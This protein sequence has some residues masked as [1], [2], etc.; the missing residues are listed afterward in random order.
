MLSMKFNAEKFCWKLELRWCFFDLDDDDQ[1]IEN[2]TEEESNDEINSY[3]AAL[4]QLIQTALASGKKKVHLNI[5]GQT[6]PFIQV[7][8]ED[9]DEQWITDNQLS[10]PCAID[11]SFFS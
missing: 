8:T 4:D 6:N 9:I 11:S 1:S 2:L 10:I 5:T 7:I 3:H